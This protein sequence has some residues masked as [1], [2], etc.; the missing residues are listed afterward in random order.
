[1]C[2]SRVRGNQFAAS[3]EVSAQ[4]TPPQVMPFLVWALLVT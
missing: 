3:V 4:L 2:E 1:M